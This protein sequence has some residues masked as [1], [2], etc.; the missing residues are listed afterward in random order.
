MRNSRMVKNSSRISS[1]ISSRVSHSSR[2][3]SS[4]RRRRNSSR[5]EN[6]H[7]SG[8]NSRRRIWSR[9]SAGIDERRC[10]IGT[11]PFLCHCPI[12]KEKSKNR[13]VY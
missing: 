6:S 7:S 12:F 10:G 13:F 1:R 5:M 4:R 8:K 9:R 3:R 11:V 2:M